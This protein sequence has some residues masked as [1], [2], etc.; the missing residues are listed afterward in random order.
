S[1]NWP[2][3]ETTVNANPGGCVLHQKS[4]SATKAGPPRARGLSRSRKCSKA[5]ERWRRTKARAPPSLYDCT[6][7]EIT[8]DG[9]ERMCEGGP[10]WPNRGAHSIGEPPGMSMILRCYRTCY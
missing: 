6:G 3:G 4:A 1:F 8:L 10:A 7:D 5:H 2:T 9:G